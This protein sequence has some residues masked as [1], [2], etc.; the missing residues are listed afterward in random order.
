MRQPKPR[1]AQM[2]PVVYRFAE[3]TL[4]S[5]R[6]VVLGPQGREAELRPKTAEVLGHLAERA[7]RVVS[8]EELM[9]AV[10]PDVV[11][12]DDSITQCVAE[13]RRAL[14]EAGAGLLRTL[15]KRGY[16][17]ATPAV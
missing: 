5:A 3:Y 9:L 11:V 17:L 10:W 6:G 14:G 12:T 13:I 2:E 7:G 8:R 15:P 4:D 1:S 16:L